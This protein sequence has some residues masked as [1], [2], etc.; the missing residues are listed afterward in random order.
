MA[1]IL[2]NNGLESSLHK[3]LI[4]KYGQE[5]ADKKMQNYM[6]ENFKNKF[7]DYQFLIDNP[8]DLIP[9]EFKNRINGETGH[10]HIIN[11]NNNIIKIEQKTSTLQK[12][13][14][15]WQHISEKHNWNILL[16]MGIHYIEIKIYI[17]T[18]DMFNILKNDK[19]Y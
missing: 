4:E 17:M 19:K 9:S 15:M 6:S 7:G 13:D 3:Q 8:S 14:F 5:V 10:D 1:C 12:N 16:L 18:R 11:H 2:L